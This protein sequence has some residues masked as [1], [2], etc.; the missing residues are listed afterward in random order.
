MTDAVLFE[1]L[2]TAS[3]HRFGSATLNAPAA[4]NALTLTMV[5]AL[6]PMLRQWVADDAIVG[7][8]LQSAGDRAFCAGADLRALYESL[9][10]TGVGEP[11]PYARTF[12]SEEYELDYL[13]HTCAKPI[14]CWGHGI[15]MG[16]GIGLMSGASHRVV[17]P[18]SRLAMPEITIGLY[19]D[20]A[21]SWLLERM[22]GRVG[23]FLGLTGAVIDAADALFCGLA[24][25]AIAAD[26][27]AEVLAA[28]QAVPWTGVARDDRAALSRQLAR[29]A[30]REL[31]ASTVRRHLDLINELL[32]GDDLREMAARLGEL[33]SD[34]AWLTK[35]VATFANGSPTSAALAFELRRRVR[36]LS[37]ADVFRLEYNVSLGC[38]AHADLVEGIRA[39]LI[40]KDRK[41]RWSPASIDEVTPGLIED[42]F[43]SRFTTP[44]P[45][46]GLECGAVAR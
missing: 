38:C 2:A 3:G 31:P 1:E 46:A 37:L 32:A 6:L 34:D 25:V 22:P 21:G 26:R 20:V 29:Y 45:L 18:Q 10:A 8:V 4:L 11:S 17:T 40:D 30:V 42:H 7:V 35:A 41:P 43:R 12:F 44:H 33:R 24:D 28:L 15:V 23:L 16:G 19:P 13:I 14:L 27:R 39:L 5:R 9:R 36:H